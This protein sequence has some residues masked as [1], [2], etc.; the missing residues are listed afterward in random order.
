MIEDMQDYYMMRDPY[1]GY[2]CTLTHQKCNGGD[3]RKCV[4]ALAEKLKET[5]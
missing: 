3:C 4:F 2:A 5:K 1:V